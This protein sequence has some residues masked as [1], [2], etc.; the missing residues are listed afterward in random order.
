[1]GEGFGIAA[2]RNMLAHV[3]GTAGGAAVALG[4]VE[5]VDVTGAAEGAESAAGADDSVESAWP[6]VVFSVD[7]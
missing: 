5:G 6:V 1:L 2:W 3:F 4:A 7:V